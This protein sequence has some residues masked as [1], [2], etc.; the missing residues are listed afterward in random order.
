[1]SNEKETIEIRPRGGGKTLEVF[2]KRE[3]EMIKKFLISEKR[4]SEL[5]KKFEGLE[6]RYETKRDSIF[7]LEEVQG[8]EIA[9]LREHQRSTDILIREYE[10]AHNFQLNEL[11]ERIVN[12]RKLDGIVLQNNLDNL[13]EVL[14]EYMNYMKNFNPQSWVGVN[15]ILEK[16]DV[17][18]ASTRE[19]LDRQTERPPLGILANMITEKKLYTEMTPEEKMLET[20]NIVTVLPETTHLFKDSGGECKFCGRKLILYKQKWICGHGCTKPAVKGDRLPGGTGVEPREDDKLCPICGKFL[21]GDK[22]WI[23]YAYSLIPMKRED[24]QFLIHNFDYEFV[25]IGE[26][27][28]FERIKEEYNIE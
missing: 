23:D 2:I 25:D 17:G 7:K 4:I 8:K 15:K 13:R 18:S 28:Y 27:Q 14:R 6:A 10:Q 11:K 21:D 5:E 20:Q 12:N 19:S 26:K 1:M 24:L 9:E 16:L 3:T 22:E